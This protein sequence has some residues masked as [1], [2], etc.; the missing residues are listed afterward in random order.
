MLRLH[1]AVSRNVQ[2]LVEKTPNT[3]DYWDTKINIT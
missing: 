1:I 3:K 2:V